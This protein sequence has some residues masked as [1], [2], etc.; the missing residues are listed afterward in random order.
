MSVYMVVATKRKLC[1][2]GEV[3]EVV[4][5]WGLMWPLTYGSKHVND[6]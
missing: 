1:S 2:C 4:R 3:G 5:G 6:T